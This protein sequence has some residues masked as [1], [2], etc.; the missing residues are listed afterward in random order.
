M[1]TFLL[2]GISVETE[3]TGKLLAYLREAGLTSVKDGCDQGACGACMV[4]I[5]GKAVRACTVRLPKLAGCSVL[6]LEGLEPA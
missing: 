6:T 2:N 5:D 3:S 4:L 1:T